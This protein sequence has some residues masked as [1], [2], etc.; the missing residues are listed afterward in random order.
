MKI[1]GKPVETAVENK[2]GRLPETGPDYQG[3][4]TGEEATRIEQEYAER[5]A[6]D[7]QKTEDL[8]QGLQNMS[9]TAPEKDLKVKSLKDK[10][11]GFFGQAPEQLSSKYSKLGE[12]R[13]QG[14]SA[15]RKAYENYLA[16][17][18]SEVAQSYKEA[19]GKWK[20]IARDKE[21]NFVDKTIYSVAS[22]EV[23]KE[24]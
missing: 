2:M 4:A 17:E 10:I 6:K 1:E 9:E 21:G 24:G 23:N 16:T 22:G 8:S 11:M 7:S 18:G 15:L 3:G 5:V 13:M 14:N 12:E 20:Y 19:V